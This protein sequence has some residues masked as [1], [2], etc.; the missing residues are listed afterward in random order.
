[1]IW[2]RCNSFEQKR[3]KY[4][5]KTRDIRKGEIDSVPELL[6]EQR[7]ILWKKSLPCT[8]CF[9][10]QCNSLSR[11]PLRNKKMIALLSKLKSLIKT[12]IYFLFLGD[13]L[14]QIKIFIKNSFSDKRNNYSNSWKLRIISVQLMEV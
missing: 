5:N 12:L 7:S 9:E 14:L 6:G 10:S 13:V 11:Q 3:I 2:K 1:M 8:H 4:S